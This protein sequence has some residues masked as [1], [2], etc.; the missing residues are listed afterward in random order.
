M[1][2]YLGITSSWTCSLL[3]GMEHLVWQLQAVE[4][5]IAGVRSWNYH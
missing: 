5:A 1:I 3:P 2:E 4:F